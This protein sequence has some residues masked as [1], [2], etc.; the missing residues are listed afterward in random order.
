MGFMIRKWKVPATLQAK[1][2]LR[3]KPQS[4][5]RAALCTLWVISSLNYSQNPW[6]LTEQLQ[7]RPGRPPL[8]W[9]SSCRSHGCSVV[10]GLPMAAA[11]RFPEPAR[12]TKVHEQFIKLVARPSRSIYHSMI[13]VVVL[14]LVLICVLFVG[15][16]FYCPSTS[17]TAEIVGSPAWLGG[18]ISRHHSSRE[19]TRTYSISFGMELVLAGWFRQLDIWI[20]RFKFWDYVLLLLNF[21]ILPKIIE[22]L[23]SFVLIN[24]FK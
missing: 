2:Q 6:N 3:L 8:G 12:M 24:F 15:C 20:E 7:F 23:L 5:A 22:I 18:T 4:R 10:I 17:Y 11:K 1:A 9:L 13:I 16:P 14:A 19:F 21:A